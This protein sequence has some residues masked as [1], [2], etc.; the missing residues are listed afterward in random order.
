MEE[1]LVE[2]LGHEYESPEN[3]ALSPAP[4]FA[5][6]TPR[7]LP[8]SPAHTAP[9]PAT[10][11]GASAV[12]AASSASSAGLAAAWTLRMQSAGNAA[13]EGRVAAHAAR[14]PPPHAAVP[15]AR[16][17]RVEEHRRSE[18]RHAQ[19]HP[20]PQR[21]PFPGCAPVWPI[22]QPY[23]GAAPYSYHPPYGAHLATV[24]QPYYGA[25]PYS[26][27]PPYGAHLAAVPQPKLP[28]CASPPPPRPRNWDNG[29]QRVEEKRRRT[30]EM[31]GVTIAPPPPPPALS[32]ALSSDMAT[33][34]GKRVLAE[35]VAALAAYSKSSGG[36]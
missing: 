34:V 32:S 22:H 17:G 6:H 23:Y 28:T 5:H 16:A 14:A 13:L 15:R 21:I 31:A 24:P 1:I 26:H 2:L 20:W 33:L 12:Q 7:T 35:I 19:A 18:E 4:D 30:A 36:K 10:G 3:V 8:L 9:P 11:G 29:K 27:H 25:A